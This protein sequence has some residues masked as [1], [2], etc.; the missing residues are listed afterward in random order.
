MSENVKSVMESR[1]GDRLDSNEHHFT[2]IIETILSI[3]QDLASPDN[4]SKEKIYSNMIY[5]D[6]ITDLP[7]KSAAKDIRTS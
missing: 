7:G 4:F 3:T 6:K 2:N 5:L 1:V